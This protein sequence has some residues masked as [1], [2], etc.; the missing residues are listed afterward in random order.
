MLSFFFDILQAVI[1]LLCLYG[2]VWYEQRKMEVCAFLWVCFIK[3]AMP[4][5][6]YCSFRVQPFFIVSFFLS[7]EV[8]SNKHRDSHSPTE[9][10]GLIQ[11]GL[12]GQL[13]SWWSY[14]GELS[15]C[16][17][18]PMPLPSLA[19]LRNSPT[20]PNHQQH[21]RETWRRSVRLT[22][23]EG[24]RY[25]ESARGWGIMKSWGKRVLRSHT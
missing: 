7:L 8:L 24:R 14:S 19:Q 6:F 18:K 5:Q 15:T 25:R 23:T 13:Y 11:D 2:M 4:L 10:C 12:S 1:T 3:M 9:P 17:L 21:K 22:T 20:V 16:T